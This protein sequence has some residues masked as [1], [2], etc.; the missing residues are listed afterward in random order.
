MAGGRP[1]LRRQKGGNG[2]GVK[3]IGLWGFISLNWSA[4]MEGG[5]G[6][7]G[8]RDGLHG[9]DAGLKQRRGRGRRKNGD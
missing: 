1:G 8:R 5:R 9:G 7:V 4:G 3:G 6:S 2:K